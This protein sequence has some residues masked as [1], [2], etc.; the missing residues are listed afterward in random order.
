M[1]IEVKEILGKWKEYTLTNTNGM[2]VSILDYGGIITKVLVPERNGRLENVILAYR[3]YQEYEDNPN[4]FGALIGRVAGRIKGASFEL[5]GESYSLPA[6]DGENHLHGG[7]EGYHKV[8]WK[9]EPFETGQEAGLRLTHTSP[10]GDSGYPGNVE[11]EVTYTLTENN[12]LKIDYA[13]TTDRATP[14]A[15][16]NHTYFNLSGNLTPMVGNHQVELDSSRFVE[17]DSSLI[18]TGRLRDVEGTLMDFR[19]PRFLEEGLDSE[20]EQ[21]Q[22]VGGYDHYFLFDKSKDVDTRVFDPHSG[23]ILSVRTTEPGMVMYTANA[24][25]D[26]IPLAEGP[27]VRHQAVCL[28]TQASPASLQLEKLPGIILRPEEKY[29]SQTIFTF[30]VEG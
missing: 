3:D 19:T 14:I 6:N 26:G 24:L 4:F 9:A 20:E 29:E 15:L 12:E 18:P 27:S 13:A 25:A 22:I 11:L 16:T 30:S 1:K 8:L 5:D 7:P 21:N 2:S 28:E 23:R 10:D 17:L